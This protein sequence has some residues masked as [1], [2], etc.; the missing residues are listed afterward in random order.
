[1]LG[2][3]LHAHRETWFTWRLT[4]RDADAW[5]PGQTG[6][7]RVNVGKIHLEGVVHF[8]AELEGWDGRRGG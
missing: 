4:A 2:K 7:D 3:D 5:D 8:F 1:M 6:G